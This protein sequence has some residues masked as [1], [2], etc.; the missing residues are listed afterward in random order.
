MRI[1]FSFICIGL[2]AL[3]F[4]A[5][6]SVNATGLASNKKDCI[7]LLEQWARDPSS[8][9]AHLVQGCQELL[10]AEKAADSALQAAVLD[11][12]ADPAAA[13]SVR[14]WGPWAALSPAAGGNSEPRITVHDE[15]ELRPELAQDLTPGVRT[16]NPPV[17]DPGPMDPTE[18]TDPTDPSMPTDPTD[19][20]DPGEPSD[21]TDPMNPVGPTDPTDP[22]NPVDPIDPVDPTP[23]IVRPMPP[24]PELPFGACGAGEACG[25]A[26][27]DPDFCSEPA[28]QHVGRFDLANDGSQFVYD[29]GGP[30]EIASLPGMTATTYQ[31]QTAFHASNGQQESGIAGDFATNGN[32]ELVVASG[33]W[34][35]GTDGFVEHGA[36]HSE[37]P[38]DGGH[39]VW[40]VASSQATLD[41]LNLDGMNNGGAGISLHFSGSLARNS[42]TTAHIQV[43]FGSQANWNGHWESAT[44]TADFS[45]GGSVHGAN[46]ISDSTRFSSNVDA[47]QSV[48]QGVILGERGAQS[49]AHAIDVLLK[50]GTVLKDAGQLT[51]QQP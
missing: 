25:F 21:P 1:V 32:G 4:T 19:P 26:L 16:P 29:Q 12:C 14:C 24:Q 48:V 20:M 13:D 47:G 30:R 22:M 9:P 36:N 8:V 15:F 31:G 18:P 6:V 23:P 42:D 44:S 40:G 50:D 37:R 43:N 11:P 3:A 28:D 27:L 46:L 10:A 17:V 33:L 49:V 45:A 7:K 41:A 51:E 39:F 5:S 34:G 35:H 2:I 38:A